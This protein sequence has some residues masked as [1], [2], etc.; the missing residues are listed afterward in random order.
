MG[1]QRPSAAAAAAQVVQLEPGQRAGADDHGRFENQKAARLVR[2][3]HCSR[4]GGPVA[5]FGRSAQRPAP[6]APSEA[7]APTQGW[8]GRLTLILGRHGHPKRDGQAAPDMNSTGTGTGRRT[9]TTFA[10][11]RL[12]ALCAL[13]ERGGWRVD[14]QCAPAVA[15]G[16]TLTAVARGRCYELSYQ[17][18]QQH[19]QPSHGASSCCCCCCCCCSSDCC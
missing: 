5:A 17:V 1:T 4:F 14:V 8:F 7:A 18:H 9:A 16:G 13:L 6:R 19:Q 11:G 15:A 2:R 3:P 10:V 12:S